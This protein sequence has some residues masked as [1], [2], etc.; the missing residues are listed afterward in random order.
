MNS[1]GKQKIS[2]QWM[3]YKIIIIDDLH[4][5]KKFGIKRLVIHIK[6]FNDEILTKSESS[7]LLVYNIKTRNKK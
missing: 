3:Y 1:C 2:E 7:P 5:I 4:F 6:I